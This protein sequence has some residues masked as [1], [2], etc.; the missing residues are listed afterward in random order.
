MRNHSCWIA[1][2]LGL[3]TSPLAVA[4]AHAQPA[5]CP[6]IDPIDLS[7]VLL[8]PPCD[9]CAITQAELAELQ[10]LQTARTPATVQHAVGDYTR[11]IERFL[12]GM[13]PPIVVDNVGAADPLFKCIN[14][15]SEEAIQAGKAKFHR[16][17]P[18]NLPNSGLQALKEVPAHDSF[19]YPSG[20]ANFGTVAGLVLT[21]MVPEL[22]EQIS[23]RIEDFG[24]SRLISAVHFRSDVMAGELAGAAVAASLFADPDFRAELAKVTPDVRKAV[25]Y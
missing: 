21:A 3:L 10:V 19:S 6:K 9:S 16:T 17:R 7:T 1:L 18:Y 4:S 20:H 15:V 24:L 11:T 13:N 8:P 22:R 12:A 25:G 2:A 5:P 23:A 14:Q